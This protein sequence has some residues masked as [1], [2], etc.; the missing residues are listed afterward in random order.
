M[1]FIIL[2]ITFNIEI[3]SYNFF[4]LFIYYLN[5]IFKKKSK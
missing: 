4:L 3:K 1:I 2:L 5:I